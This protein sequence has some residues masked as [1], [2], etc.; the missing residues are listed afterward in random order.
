MTRV[1]EKLI[2]TTIIKEIPN[3]NS[4]AVLYNKTKDSYYLQTA[5]VNF[6]ILK[7]F[8]FINPKNV[9][10]NDIQAI[11][12]KFGVLSFLCRLKQPE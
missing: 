6:D 1:I 5:G 4:V 10:S 2:T 3:I 7:N 8:N 9:R 12:K 11:A